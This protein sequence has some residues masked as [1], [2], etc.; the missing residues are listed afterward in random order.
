MILD[1]D[2]MHQAQC[3]VFVRDIEDQT[4]Y[5]S[6]PA[7]NIIKFFRIEP[8]NTEWCDNSYEKIQSQDP[9]SIQPDEIP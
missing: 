5:L 9:T 7:S 3:L 1:F 8:E 6:E 2:D 4:L